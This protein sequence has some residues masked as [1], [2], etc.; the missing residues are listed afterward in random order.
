MR[1]QNRKEE[2]NSN[3]KEATEP[4]LINSDSA[5][6]QDQSARELINET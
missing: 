5:R 3:R 1:E 6:Q 2:Q 4:E